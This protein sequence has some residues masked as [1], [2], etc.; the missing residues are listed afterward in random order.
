MTQPQWIVF[1][2]IGVLAEPSWRDLVSQEPG[3]KKRWEDLKRGTAEED[4]F[5][6][7]A[8]Q[9]TYRSVLDFRADRL[10]LVRGLR[11]R[12][13]HVAIASNFSRKWLESLL[14]KI[15]DPEIFERTLVSAEVGA[16]KPDPE[17]WERVKTFAPPGSIFVDDQIRN[18]DA[19]E[20][21]GY[22]AVW[23]HPGAQLRE[24][25]EQRLTAAA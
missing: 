8:L 16:A 5:W 4:A 1:D 13:V 14:G 24:E 18:C 2:L 25:L 21:A 22:R 20:K 3:I 19:A 7:E 6:S 10:E 9:K 17:F 12:G 11:R 23:A 15:P